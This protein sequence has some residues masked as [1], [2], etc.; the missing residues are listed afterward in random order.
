MSKLS[1]LNWK[2]TDCNATNLIEKENAKMSATLDALFNMNLKNFHYDS[3]K[4]CYIDETK[5][6]VVSIRESEKN[7][8]LQV[9]VASDFDSLVNCKHRNKSEDIVID[10]V[11][12]VR[13]MHVWA[14]ATKIHVYV[15]EPV[16]LNM[17]QD[18][19]KVAQKLATDLKCINDSDKLFCNYAY[20]FELKSKDFDKIDTLAEYI[21]SIASARVATYTAEKKDEKTA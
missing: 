21:D 9:N 2:E 8:A 4:N 15:D 19:F 13:V 3:N 10:G 14:L 5:K 20:R 6:V 11:A 12:Y 17:L 16:A 1:E 18:C 7:I